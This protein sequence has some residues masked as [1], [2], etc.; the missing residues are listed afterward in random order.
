VDGVKDAVG[1]LDGVQQVEVELGTRLVRITPARDRTLDLAAVGPAVR[2]G[3]AR[4]VRMRIVAE[5]VV[6]PQA[7]FR[8]AGWPTAYAIDGEAPP[9]GPCSLRAN[10]H[11]ARDGPRLD[12]VGG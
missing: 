6:E 2:S 11:I 12:P 1:R 3:G 5:G 9:E 8:I 10:V 4:M 7:R